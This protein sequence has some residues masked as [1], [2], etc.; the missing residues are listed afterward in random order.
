MTPIF[1]PGAETYCFDLSAH[2]KPGQKQADFEGAFFDEFRRLC[3]A[4]QM[5][6]LVLDSDRVRLPR[7]PHGVKVEH[8]RGLGLQVWA[9]SLPRVEMGR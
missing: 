7:N 9:S 2:V 8:I 6:H 4:K 1:A 5:R 3:E